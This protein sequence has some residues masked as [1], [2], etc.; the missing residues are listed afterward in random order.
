[1]P[2]DRP[3]ITSSRIK[4]LPVSARGLRLARIDSKER[5]I[6]CETVMFVDGFRSVELVLARAEISGR[7]EVDGKIENHFADVMSDE[8]SM[9]ETV[10][11][12]A[13]SYRALK[14]HWMRC[15][16]NAARS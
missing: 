3:Q 16:V 11:L 8:N 5:L 13:E 10:A 4:G 9:V 2:S 12:D 7:V 1:M 15:K 14:N 6:L